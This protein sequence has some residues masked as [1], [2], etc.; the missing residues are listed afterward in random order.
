MPSAPL[1]ARA[2]AEADAAPVDGAAVLE[3]F[4]AAGAVYG[5]R[6]VGV[7]RGP[8]WLDP[9]EL[10]AWSRRLA[11]FH[12]IVRVVR[13][14]LLADLDRDD[15][16]AAR[17]GVAPRGRAWAAVDPGYRSAA[18]LARLDTFTPTGGDPTFIELNA[19]APAGMGY[20]GALTRVLASL[21]G[22][23]PHR[24]LD[25]V[26][27][28][29]RAL[30]GI[31]AEAGVR[32][33]HPRTAI[34]DFRGGATAPEL[35]LLA[36]RLNAHGLP[37]QV[38]DPG[39]LGFDGERL[40]LGGETVEVVY[41]RALVVELD[42]AP[43]RAR[44][45][46]DAYLARRVVMVNPLRTAL[47][48][49]KGLF[50]LFFDPEVLPDPADRRFVARF[51]PWTGLLVGEADALR[52]RIWRSPE[53]WVIKPVDLHGGSGVV[54]GREVDRRTWERA[55]EKAR[56]HVAQRWVPAPSAEFQDLRD[57]RWHRRSYTLDPFLVR[58]RLA[59]FLARV[60]AGPLGNV[61]AGGASQTPVWIGA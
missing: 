20:A 22:A 57:G 10:A 50:A 27:F 38:A 54:V 52:E 41:R 33:R 40:S 23:L 29:V 25:P 13:A 35:R 37:A 31:A 60:F 1:A 21:P 2:R 53:D 14:R 9:E 47:L 19:E 15:G 28:L 36:E 51:V 7:H 12:R 59:G 45:L 3:R 6:P 48:H 30:R 43:E 16:L 26:P 44:A 17:I 39:E 24:H 32:S 11:R 61:T 18:P 55:V 42:A 5:D 34:V 4:I 58:G 49:N 46:L 8:V 56:H